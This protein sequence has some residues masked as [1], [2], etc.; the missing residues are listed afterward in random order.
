MFEGF[1]FAHPWFI[2]L[3]LPFLVCAFF[4]KLKLPSFYFPHAQKFSKEIAG[5]SR[6]LQFLKWFALTAFVLAMMS[7]VKQTPYTMPPKNGI[8]IALVLDTSGSMNS[9]GFDLYNPNIS[10]FDVVKSIVGQFIKQRRNDNI[11]IVVFGSYSFVAAPLTYDKGILSQI[12]SQL[13]VGMAGRYT[14][15]YDALAQSVGL[16]R[17]SHAKTKVAI[18]LTDGY[19]TQQVT[20]IPLQAALAMANKYGIKIYTIGIGNDFNKALLQTI[21]S[22]TGA[23]TFGARNASELQAVYKQ[24]DRLE[25]S[26]IRSQSFVYKKYYFFYPLFIGFLALLA[27]IV[28]VNKR[29]HE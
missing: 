8:D 17:N 1:S 3:L 10:R 25:K 19:N 16:L 5:R 9:G 4:C 26:K 13:H 23:Q 24:I 29:G 28:I 11:G 7:P 12:V 22:S 2:L 15:L 18:L 21:A 27:Y 6:F 20:R 14:A